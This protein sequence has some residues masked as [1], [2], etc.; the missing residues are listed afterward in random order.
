MPAPGAPATR[1]QGSCDCLHGADAAGT[2]TLPMLQLLAFDS[3]NVRIYSTQRRNAVFVNQFHEVWRIRDQLLQKFA[4]NP[5]REANDVGLPFPGL[6]FDALMQVIRE[7]KYIAIS[8]LLYLLK[9]FDR[10]IA[11]GLVVGLQPAYELA[12]IEV[13]N[14]VVNTRL[15][16]AIVICGHKTETVCKIKITLVELDPMTGFIVK[17]LQFLRNLYIRIFLLFFCGDVVIADTQVPLINDGFQ[18]FID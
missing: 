14:L 11:I 10:I 7:M 8:D 5:K 9:S 18:R 12:V 2:A 13:W 1:Q 4:I 6:D 16:D 3:V 17:A 15:K